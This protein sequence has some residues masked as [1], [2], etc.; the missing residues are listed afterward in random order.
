MPT[1]VYIEFTADSPV[2]PTPR[3]LHA[4]LSGI[5]DLPVGISPQRAATLPALAVRPVHDA[6]GPKPYS[7]GQLTTRLGVLGMEVR[8]LDDRL[9]ST[10][11][12]WL[13]WGGVL[14]LGSGDEHTA[15][16]CAQ[17]AEVIQTATWQELADTT[18]NT[19]WEITLLSPTVFS[20]HAQH[21]ADFTAVSFAD[22][23]HA[24]W[25][26]WN[27]GYDFPLP[28]RADL[29]HL[30]VMDDHTRPVTVNLGMPHKDRRGR[31]ASRAI[32]A[33]EG[34]MRISGRTGTPATA[35][36]S[37]LMALAQFTSVGSHGAFG[38]GLIDVVPSS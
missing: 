15:L 5:L 22:S 7:L 14:P 9:V 29:A 3:R 28:R 10:L 30:L 4:A 37:R 25:R 24:R 1:T 36:F 13:A 26:A 8:F 17:Q 6:P 21:T 12:A 31:L 27:V 20:R 19:A 11:D 32:T 34:R 33:R 2:E 18:D 38:M 16:L 23:L 35:A